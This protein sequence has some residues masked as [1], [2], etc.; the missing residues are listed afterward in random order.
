MNPIDEIIQFDLPAIV[1]TIKEYSTDNFIQSYADQLLQIRYPS[2][3]QRMY[4]LVGRLLA[5]YDEAI[6]DIRKDKYLHAKEAHMK[7]H[8]LLKKLF[9]LLCERADGGC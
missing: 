1:K 5:W 6:E 9:H 3:T 4:V 2:E 7:S 8:V